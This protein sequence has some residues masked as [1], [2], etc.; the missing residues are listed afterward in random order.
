MPLFSF[1]TPKNIRKPKGF[2]CFQGV[3]K[4]TSGI[5]RDKDPQNLLTEKKQKKKYIVMNVL[6]SSIKKRYV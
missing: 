5:K 4:Q 2:W 1:N 3:S 6:L